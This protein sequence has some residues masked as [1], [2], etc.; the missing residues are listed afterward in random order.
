VAV[1]I[2]VEGTGV[3]GGFAAILAMSLLGALLVVPAL[4]LLR[5]AIAALPF[6]LLWRL[7]LREV[8]G[9]PRVLGVALAALTLAV[10]TGIGIG[11]MVESF[12]VDFTRMLDARLAGDLYVSRAASDLPALDQ[13]LREQPEVVRV[14]GF[15]TVRVRLQGV[16]A[17]LGYARFDR[18]GSARYGFT[19]PLRTGEA[20]LN[21][22]LARDLGVT[23]GAVVD[24][25]GSA[26]SAGRLVVAGTFPGFGEASGRLLVDL[27]TLDALALAPHFDRLTVDLRP[28]AELAERLA[29]RFPTVQVE[30]RAASR[31][32][33]LRIFDRTFA[34]TQA[35][36]LLALVVAVVGI[37]NALTALRLNQAP[38]TRLLHAQGLSR[39]EARAISLIRSATVG[40][41]AALLALPLGIAM[42]WTLCTVI[43]PRSFG[44]SVNLHLPLEAWLLPAL[45][46]IGAALLAGAVPAPRERGALEDGA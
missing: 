40:A 32:Q 11:L 42:A 12:R 35:L 44:W 4:G 23:P 30:A 19:R 16:P 10:A 18:A 7:A 21:E 17:E 43:N 29:R 5:R 24:L 28:G 22:R 20:L 45:L 38:T 2:L 26:G 25:V 31:A 8:A 39:G 1:G 3:F 46:G 36:T 37:Y 6:G 14:S 33:A 13:W 9:Q 27:A 15:G 34:I 41:L